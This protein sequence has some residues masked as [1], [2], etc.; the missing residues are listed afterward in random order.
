MLCCRLTIV[1]VL[2]T[3]LDGVASAQ[4][5]PVAAQKSAVKPSAAQIEKAKPQDKFFRAIETGNTKFVLD[6]LD[7]ELRE[8][9]DDPVVDAWVAV[10]KK[11]LGDYKGLSWTDFKTS[12]NYVD[13]KKIQEAR[14]MFLFENDKVDAE[15]T[16]RDGKLV[17]FNVHPRTIGKTWSHRPSTTKLYEERAISFVKE[18]ANGDVD[19]A[20]GLM[21]ESLQKQ[22]SLEQLKGVRRLVDQK[23]GR[24][25]AAKIERVEVEI[26][27]TYKLTIFLELDFENVKQFGTV[28]FQFTNLR[29]Y[30]T[31]FNLA[32][33][34][35]FDDEKHDE[36]VA[37]FTAVGRNDHNAALAELHTKLQKEIDPP[38]FHAWVNAIHEVLGEY[39]SANNEFEY[40]VA[41]NNGIKFRTG[42]GALTFEK[43]SANA[44]FQCYNREIAA[45]KLNS[46]LLEDGWFKGP[47]DDPF[48]KDKASGF[49]TALTGPQPADAFEMMH[50]ALLQQTSLEKFQKGFGNFTAAHGALKSLKYSSEKFDDTNGHSLVVE[51]ETEF[52]NGG[53]STAFVLFRFIGLKA[54]I[55]AFDIKSPQ[56]A[57]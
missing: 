13:G 9:L 39:K 56:A 40:K 25:K 57:K 35:E 7:P 8:K 18:L 23:V 43:G 44:Q 30:L 3:I 4:D 10:L 2:L 24:L 51:F 28:G 26:D 1:A 54:H 49:L 50:P 29:G 53:K 22:M 52:V 34:A 32:A 38:V 33:E 41:Y 12:V 6:L 11:D 45:F 14:G 55:L 46:E 36:A 15:F 21:H 42:K 17:K 48:Y 5:E 19:A 47:K 37:F 31:S 16:Y 27:K 20:F